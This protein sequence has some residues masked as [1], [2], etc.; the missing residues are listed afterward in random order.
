M[1]DRSNA[2]QCVLCLVYMS[3]IIASGTTNFDLFCV[4]MIE[5]IMIAIVCYFNLLF[6]SLKFNWNCI[7]ICTWLSPNSCSIEPIFIGVYGGKHHVC[8][9]NFGQLFVWFLILSS[10][11][12][13]IFFIILFSTPFRSIIINTNTKLHIQ[14]TSAHTNRI[15]DSN[16]NNKTWRGSCDMR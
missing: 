16:N 6:E 2:I 15:Q 14:L 8:S 3:L 13:I 9:G 7:Y 5:N 4:K 11:T 12:M 1:R 10:A